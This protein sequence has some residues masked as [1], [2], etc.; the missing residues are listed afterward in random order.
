[1]HLVNNPKAF[2]QVKLKRL[3]MFGSQK[4]STA[5]MPIYVSGCPFQLLVVFQNGRLLLN[6]LIYHLTRSDQPRVDL[7]K[8]LRL[9]VL[10]QFSRID[11][12]AAADIRL[13]QLLV[14]SR[15]C[16]GLVHVGALRAD[17]LFDLAVQR[18]E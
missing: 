1:M 9:D 13:Y 11:A 14:P 5:S 16:Q 2:P 3:L 15:L 10:N 18:P 6:Q 8:A 12:S 17:Q 7:V 4:N